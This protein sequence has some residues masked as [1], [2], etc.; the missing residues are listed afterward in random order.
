MTFK[1]DL[2]SWSTEELQQYYQHLDRELLETKTKLHEVMDEL[3]KRK[4]KELTDY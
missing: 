4:T 2:H 3:T 1:I